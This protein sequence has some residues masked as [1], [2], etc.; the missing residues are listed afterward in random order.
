MIFVE[1][2]LGIMVIMS[3]VSFILMGRDKS[4]AKHH[5]WRIPESTLLLA[6]LCMGG[7][8]AWIG[9]KVFHHKTKHMKFQVLVP[10]CAMI[11]IVG[12]AIVYIK[13]T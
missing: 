8:G 13:F 10:L 3:F 7:I 12:L 2:L 6:A 5:G 4:L 11:Q 9:M 1:I